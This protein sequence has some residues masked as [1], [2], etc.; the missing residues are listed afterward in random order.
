MHILNDSNYEEAVGAIRHILYMYVD[1][2][3]GWQGFGHNS[4]T[5]DQFD[6][7]KFVDADTDGQASYVDL[8]L[9]RAGSA[10]A[11]L[12]QFYDIWSEEGDLTGNIFLAEYQAAVD[13]GRLSAFPDI[14]TVIR[15]ALARDPMPLE[16]PW[17]EDAVIPIYR[18]YVLGFFARLA[19]SDRS[20]ASV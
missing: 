15:T 17:F 12:C 3:Q 18:K 11:I 16:D 19:A 7:V 9:L 14:E 4:G 5:A 13:A 2:V 8:D 20:V 6:A 1:L 10:I